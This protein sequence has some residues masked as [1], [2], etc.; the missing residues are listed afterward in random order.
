MTPPHPPPLR[1]L[2]APDERVDS[3]VSLALLLG[4]YGLYLLFIVVIQYRSISR[5]GGLHGIGS[6]AARPDWDVMATGSS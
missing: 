4:R 2:R 6:K 5:R 1:P 3:Y